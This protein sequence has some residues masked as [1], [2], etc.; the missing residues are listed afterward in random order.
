MNKIDR[1]TVKGQARQIIKNRVFVLFIITFIVM[2]LTNFSLISTHDLDD[3]IDGLKDGYNFGYNYGNDNK[4]Y[5]DDFDLDDY[6]EKS[7]GVNDYD[8]NEEFDEG[9]FDDFSPQSYNARSYGFPKVKASL[10]FLSG[11][12]SIISLALSPL[13]VTL[14]GFYLALVRRNPSEE[15]NFG[16]ELKHLF[17]SSFN[18][19]YGKK[20]G[21]Y[22]FRELIMVLL[23]LLFVIPGIVFYY[24]SY[25]AFQIKCECP[26]LSPM[27]CI[28]LSKKMI[29]GN[30]GELFVLDLSFIAWYLLV[31]ITAGIACI[32]VFP[33]VM[34]TQ[35]L[36]YQNFKIRALME[37]KVSE[38]D[39][40]SPQQRATD[41]AQTQ[42][43]QYGQ[44]NQ[45]NQ[46]N[47][48]QQDYSGYQNYQYNQTNNNQSADNSY[49]YS[50]PQPENDNYFNGAYTPPESTDEQNNN[51]NY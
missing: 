20:L 29:K 39:F 15:L 4:D 50:P 25:F 5:D 35:A 12:S 1:A 37:G 17:K 36:Y 44:Y 33:Y 41:Y 48:P 21:V 31:V 40:K 6:F 8:N 46:Y 16:F 42:Y 10:S 51:D 19:T 49:Y 18:E 9:A 11:I 3:F 14:M 34:T 38:D 13:L 23:S 30:R 2:A 43:N 47:Q 45:Y 24:S 7:F 27:E 22:F 26:E 32:Y 28:R